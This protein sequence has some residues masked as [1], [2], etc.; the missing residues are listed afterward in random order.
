MLRPI[1]IRLLVRWTPPWRCVE[2]LTKGAAE[3]RTWLA[4]HPA[5]GRGPKGGVQSNQADYESA[6]MVTGKGVIQG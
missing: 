5:D 1:Q 4:R 2:R 3:I 6:K